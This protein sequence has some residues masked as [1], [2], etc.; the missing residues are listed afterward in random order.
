MELTTAIANDVCVNAA[1]CPHCSAPTTVT[2]TVDAGQWEREFFKCRACDFRF[3]G[4]WHTQGARV[5]GDEGWDG[6]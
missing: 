6:G 1:L 2:A 4:S 5:R 3:A